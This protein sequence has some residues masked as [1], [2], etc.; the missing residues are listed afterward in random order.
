MLKMLHL[1]HFST[2]VNFS[3][4]HHKATVIICHRC[5]S[6]LR[7]IFP[8]HENFSKRHIGPSE[9]QQ[10]EML[11]LVGVKVIALLAFSIKLDNG[12][13]PDPVI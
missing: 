7:E 6:N 2:A 11:D 4:R 8:K 12:Y 10:K 5:A 1:K 3:I 9:D 13:R